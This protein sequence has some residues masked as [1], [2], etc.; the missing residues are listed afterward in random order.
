[1]FII[2]DLYARVR[3]EMN[4]LI[5]SLLSLPFFTCVLEDVFRELDWEDKYDITVNGKKL[6]NLRF[7]DDIVLFSPDPKNLQAIHYM[8]I[9]LMIF[10]LIV[11]LDRKN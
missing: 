1:M 10:L 7:A 5:L 2:C 4:V 3:T 6:T 11:M 8:Y 9:Y